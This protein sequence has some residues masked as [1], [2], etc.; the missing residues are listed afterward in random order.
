[1]TVQL[2]RFSCVTSNQGIVSRSIARK[3]IHYFFRRKTLQC[4]VLRESRRFFFSLRHENCFLHNRWEKREPRDNERNTN[5]CC[6]RHAEPD[7]SRYRPGGFVTQSS[8]C[9]RQSAGDHRRGYP[10]SLVD[11]RA[12]DGRS[13]RAQQPAGESIAVPFWRSSSMS[14]TQ[15]RSLGERASLAPDAKAVGSL[16]VL[17]AI[18]HLA[19]G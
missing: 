5:G 4:K 11:L 2:R 6:K 12:S 3:A 17:N 18:E 19:N 10:H 13:S 8:P 14:M 15:G 9:A 7:V 16:L 1:M